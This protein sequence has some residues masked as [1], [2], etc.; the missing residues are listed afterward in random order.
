MMKWF[1]KMFRRRSAPAVG[2]CEQ[3]PE[4]KLRSF[5]YTPVRLGFSES[6]C[7]VMEHME[8]W[9]ESKLRRVPINDLS[10]DACDP[11]IDAICR[12]EKSIAY[13]SSAKNVR[14]V[15][16]IIDSCNSEIVRSE[17]IRQM[18]LEE[19]KKHQRELDELIELR[20]SL[21]RKDDEDYYEE[22]F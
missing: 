5:N 9:A 18:L 10:E 4:K 21:G 6:F 19:R 22:D 14:T 16:E 8:A 1:K 11:E 13:S 2:K 3:L 17:R 20:R 7:R 12:L 15:K